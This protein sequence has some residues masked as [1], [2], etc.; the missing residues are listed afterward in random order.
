MKKKIFLIAMFFGFVFN[1]NGQ[2]KIDTLTNEKIIQLTKIG[3]QPSVIVN[4]IK[5]SKNIFD[6]STDALIK[7]TEN[8]VATEVIN[9]MMFVD[10]EIQNIVANYKD[11]KDPLSMRE[12]GIYYLDTKDTIK[13]IKKID[14]TVVAGSKS[15]GGSFEGIGSSSSSSSL[16]GGKSL[17]QINDSL[18]VFYFYFEKNYKPGASNWFF[19][20]AA[21]PKEFCLIELDASRNDRSFKTGK[22]SSVG[23][24]GGG[25]VGIPEKDKVPFVYTEIADGIYKVTFNQTLMPGEYCFLYAGKAPSMFSNDKVFDFGINFVSK[26]GKSSGRFPPGFGGSGPPNPFKRK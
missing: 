16:S 1:S 21:S 5:K 2:T 10:S 14:A 20:T 23:G 6:V 4:K 24:F 18:Y 11:P 15:G 22:S 12:A 3:L 17:T 7:L 25:S 8:G 9:E 19:A 26:K 13:P